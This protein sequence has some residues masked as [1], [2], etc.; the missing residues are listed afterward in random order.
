MNFSNHWK[1]AR[2]FF[3]SLEKTLRTFPIIGKT[4][5]ILLAA[6][7]AGAE[8]AAPR[9][10]SLSPNL[11]E[12]VFAL[13]LESHLAGRSSACDYP[14]A[15]R[16]LPVAGEFGRPN[17]EQL[18]LL[19]P[20]VLLV[21]DLEKPEMAAAL[22]AAGIQTKVLPCESWA[23][24]INAA[25]EIA[26]LCGKPEAGAKWAAEMSSRRRQLSEKVDAFFEGK[27]RPLVY[28]EIWASPLTTAGGPSFIDDMIR[29][30]G[31]RN[32]GAGLKESYAHVSSEWVIR[33]NPDIVALAWMKDGAPDRAGLERRPGWDSIKAIQNRSVIADISP[34]LLLRSG[35]RMMLGAEELAK[36]FMAAAANGAP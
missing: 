7:L 24:L 33:E 3:Q 19:K 4:G 8:P 29:L 6:S 13:G 10:A 11:T 2:H 30:A 36:R 12:V 15:A 32:I 22:A 28:M 25:G 34:D 21:T 26:R 5:L 20:D 17:V 27:S 14:P 9:I 1:N 23:S 35:P 16:A 31:G 18:L